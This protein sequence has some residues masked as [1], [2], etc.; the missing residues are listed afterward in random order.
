MLSN[1]LRTFPPLS[2]SVSFFIL[3]ARTR[4]LTLLLIWWNSNSRF[5]H[6]KHYTEQ[7]VEKGVTRE[8][9][10]FSWS[11]F[12]VSISAHIRER[13]Y[14]SLYTR[15]LSYSSLS[16]YPRKKPTRNKKIKNKLV[17][18]FY[19]DNTQSVHTPLYLT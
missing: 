12:S 16:P 1:H 7:Y 9:L 18:H 6:C 5:S 15:T 13:A 11:F 17:C 19:Y 14:I 10:Y 4:S 2:L 8:L 3:N